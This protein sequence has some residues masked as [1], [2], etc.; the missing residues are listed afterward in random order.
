M[1]TDYIAKRYLPS[2]G[3]LRRLR[4]RL[5]GEPAQRLMFYHTGTPKRHARVQPPVLSYELRWAH[6]LGRTRVEREEFKV[7][8]ATP[9]LRELALALAP[10]ARA[11]KTLH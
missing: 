10:E 6:S 11:G 7:Q 9:I 5:R 3:L 4:A 1:V 8:Q 2:P